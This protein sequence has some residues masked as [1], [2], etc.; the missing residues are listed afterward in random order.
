MG[1]ASQG[2]TKSG[3]SA[4]ILSCTSSHTT[5]ASFRKQTQ[6]KLTQLTAR[7]GGSCG[8]RSGCGEYCGGCG[9]G[10]SRGGSRSCGGSRSDSRGRT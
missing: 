10:G 2:D 7:S 1:R 9:C 3:D 5:N 8:G 4:S 6:C